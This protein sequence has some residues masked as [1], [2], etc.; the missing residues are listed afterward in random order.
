[1]DLEEIPPELII[2]WDQTAIHYVPVSSWSMEVEG[3]KQ[4]EVVGKDNKRQITAC[5]AGSMAGDFLPLQ[6]VYEGKTARCLPRVEFPG[7]WH[8]TY[9][10]THWSNKT[11]MKVYVDQNI[12]PYITQKRVELKSAPNHAS[13]L[14]FDNFRA[15]RTEYLLTY[16]NSHNVYVVLIPPNCTDKLQPLDLSVNKPVKDFLWDKF[17]QWYS[18]IICH[19]F[20]GLQ[21]K[22]PV[23]LRLA[24]VKPSGARWMISLYEYF[25]SKPEI[26]QHGFNFI[27]NYLKSSSAL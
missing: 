16:I 24:V 25:K 27:S 14:L 7:D 21:S 23:D 5:F 12:L 11:T 4:V 17:Q 15:Q 6:L 8:I 10:S 18:G 26:I 22:E 1:M 19:Q 9:S 13:L 20:Q 3:S 2:N